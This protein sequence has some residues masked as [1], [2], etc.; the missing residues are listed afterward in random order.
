LGAT[1][2]GVVALV[3]REAFVLL[4]FGLA[5]GMAGALGLTRLLER[6]LYQVSALDPVTYT[7]VPLLMLTTTVMACVVPSIRAAVIDPMTALR[8]E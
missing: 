6:F 7:L 4:A 5:I 8:H 3:L 2:W 1:R